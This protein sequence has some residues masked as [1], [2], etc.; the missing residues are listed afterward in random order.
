MRP[1]Y[2]WIEDEQGERRKVMRNYTTAGGFERVRMLRENEALL[3]TGMGRT[4]FR[5]W[6]KQIG[7]A[8]HFGKSLR[9]D[10]TIIDAEL[11]K[12]KE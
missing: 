8:K 5:A 10:R 9:Y 11:D 2:F 6:A 12:V 7:A 1:E 3:Y 4:S